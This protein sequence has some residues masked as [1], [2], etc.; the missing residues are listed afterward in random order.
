MSRALRQSRRRRGIAAVEAAVVLPV[1]VLLTFGF[2]EIGYLV[3]SYHILHDAARQGARAAVGPENSNAEVQAAVLSSLNNSISVDSN[4]VTVR[5]SKLDSV[6]EE[7][8]QVMNLSANEQGQAIRVTVTV[9]Y[10]EFRPPSSILG[11]GSGPLISSV[12]MQRQK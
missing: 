11:T 7:D 9:D 6:G 12:V 3:D 8:Y 1:I 10:A 4:A 5:I 2:I